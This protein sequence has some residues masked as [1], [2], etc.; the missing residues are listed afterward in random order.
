[1]A[2]YLRP[3]RGKKATAE[4]QNIVLKKGEIFFEVPTGGVGKGIGKLK[5]G[6]GTTAYKN[7]PYF[8]EQRA[9]TDVANSTIAFT[10]TS[11][12]N[13]T[14]LLNKIAN[15]AKLN[16]IIPAIKNLLSNLNNSVTQLNNDLGNNGFV[17]YKYRNTRIFFLW[18]TGKPNSSGVLY[19]DISSISIPSGY[20]ISDYGVEA[21]CTSQQC[22]CIAIYNAENKRIEISCYKTDYPTQVFVDYSV[23]KVFGFIYKV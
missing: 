13:N 20:T 19:Y 15:N 17:N 12:T 5:M 1:M 2:S 8:L 23:F 22:R 11:E 18:T 4:S 7:L 16:V 6:D 10:A 21:F 14:T 3:R 9:A